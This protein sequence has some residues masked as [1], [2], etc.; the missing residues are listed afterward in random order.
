MSNSRPIETPATALHAGWMGVALGEARRAL[1]TGDVPIGAVVLG[2]DGGLLG[3]GRNE[4]EAHGDPTAHAEMVAIREAAQRLGGWRLE[5]CTLVVTLEP[6]TMCAGA[7]VLARLPKVVFGAWDE[8]AG[9][10]GSV[11]DV[12]RERR[13]NHW[14]EVFPGVRQDECAAL[15]TDFFGA[16]R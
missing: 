16:R 1:D 10:A 15:L 4:R 3:V 12:L 13:L 2:S 14:V 6:C 7:I 5:G 11:F 8:K 9:A